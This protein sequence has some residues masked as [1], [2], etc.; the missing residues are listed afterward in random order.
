MSSQ[1]NKKITGKPIQIVDSSKNKL[2]LNEE[3]LRS[4][5]SHENAVDK[6]VSKLR[7]CYFGSLHLILKVFLIVSNIVLFFAYRFVLSL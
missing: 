5:L 2:I 4:I 7:M 1:P 3:N 6:K